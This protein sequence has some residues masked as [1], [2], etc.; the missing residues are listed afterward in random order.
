MKENPVFDKAMSLLVHPLTVAAIALYALNTFV[1]QHITPNWFTG[2]LGDFAWIFAA[3][4]GF[5]ALAAW[6]LPQRLRQAAFP[7]SILGTGL[8][9]GL[10]KATPINALLVSGLASLIGR[11]VSV[12]QD[13]SDLLAL[14]AIPLTAWNWYRPRAGLRP[15]RLAGV[16]LFAVLAL[17]TAADSAAPNLGVTSIEFSGNTILACNTYFSSYNFQSNDGGLTWQNSKVKC[18]EAIFSPK[19]GEIQLDPTDEKTQYRFNPGLIERSSD[20]GNTWQADYQWTLP[21]EAEKLYFISSKH[22]YN[23]TALPPYSAAVDPQTG[24]VFFAMGLE[25]ILKRTAGTAPNYSW[26]TIGEFQKN[27]FSKSELLFNLL[28][29]EWMLAISAGGIGV[30]WLDTKLK[31]GKGKTAL[32]ILGLA[33]I[34]ACMIIVPPAPT[35]ASPYLS[36]YLVMALV[37]LLL[38]MLGLTANALFNA[39]TKSKRWLFYYIGDFLVVMILF[40][41]P[42]ALW[43]YNVIPYY[44]NAARAAA[45]AAGAGVIGLRIIADKVIPVEKQKS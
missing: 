16:G 27:N 39:G 2:K 14:L 23:A 45:I 30:T 3:P 8:I 43:A 15:G 6:L 1:L 9:F 17:V 4:L 37:G 5:T 28:Y 20:E 34:A 31:P 32:L 38:L 19:Y 11:P 41:L 10:V 44:P 25:G 22:A 36:Q 12:V 7:L 33:G 13:G 40:F 26:I 29:G 35:L 24:E 21:S 42:F 18:S